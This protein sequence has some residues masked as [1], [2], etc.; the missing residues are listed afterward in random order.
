[1]SLSILSIAYLGAAAQG[2]G[3]LIDQMTQPAF[4]DQ[5]ANQ[6]TRLGLSAPAIL[7]L[8]AHKPLAFV[9]SQ[10]LLVAQPTLDLFLPP[11]LSRNFSD[12]LANQDQFEQLI[13]I[14]EHSGSFHKGDELL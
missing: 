7:I 14:L 5:V 1:L 10:L 13:R 11:N 8:E 12:L 9:G 3:D 4:I 6:I 2:L